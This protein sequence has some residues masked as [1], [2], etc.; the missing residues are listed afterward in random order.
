MATYNIWMHPICLSK[1]L[2]LL[3]KYS[4]KHMLSVV[5]Q[6]VMK[7]GHVLPKLGFFS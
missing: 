5:W 7:V 6:E 3:L 2:C 1:C 4:F